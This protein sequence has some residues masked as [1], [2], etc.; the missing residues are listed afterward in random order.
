MS[1]HPNLV[2]LNQKNKN[3]KGP[4]NCILTM[5]PLFLVHCNV[6]EASSLIVSFSSTASPQGREPQV[7]FKDES[8]EAQRN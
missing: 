3:K 1:E 2:K 8:S 5:F 6:W 4:E 7:H